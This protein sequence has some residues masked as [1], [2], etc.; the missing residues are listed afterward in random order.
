MHSRDEIVWKVR[1]AVVE[2][3]DLKEE[4][5]DDNISFQNDLKADSLDM[6]SLAIVLE[7]EFSAEIEDEKVENFV[8][9]N[10]VID[11]IMD[12]QQQSAA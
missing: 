7:D 9:I 1:D 4:I 5:S 6:V 8:T 10:N 11:Y 2:T 3:F 12:R